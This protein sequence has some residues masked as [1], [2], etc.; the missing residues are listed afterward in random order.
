MKHYPTPITVTN[1]SLLTL[2]GNRMVINR[3]A[4]TT[5]AVFVTIVN[6]ASSLSSLASFSFLNTQYF[7]RCA[8][9]NARFR[10]N[11]TVYR[12]WTANVG[13]LLI[14]TTHCHDYRGNLYFHYKYTYIHAYLY[15][16]IILYSVMSWMKYYIRKI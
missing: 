14:D 5:V 15:I 16:H 7:I 2:I 3:T 10:Y 8:Q 9:A 11:S 6:I 12:S 4:V 1:T 13:A